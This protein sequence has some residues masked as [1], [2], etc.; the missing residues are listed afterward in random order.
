MAY[1][2]ILMDPGTPWWDIVIVWATGFMGFYCLAVAMEGYFRRELTW[3]ER[4]LFMGAAI[5][6]F[7]QIWWIK[8]AAVALLALGVALQT[9]MREAKIVT[10]SV[11][12]GE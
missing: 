9:R 4:T 11:K 10:A 3:M 12:A 2:P 8:V 1:S 5:A 6:F 7:F